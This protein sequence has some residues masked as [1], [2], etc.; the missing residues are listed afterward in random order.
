MTATDII[1]LISSKRLPY[2]TEL[3]LQDALEAVFKERG[4]PYTREL[5]LNEKDRIDFWVDGVGIEVKIKGAAKQT[6]RQCERYCKHDEIKELLL[7]T[8]K[9]IGFPPDINGKP[10]YVYFLSMNML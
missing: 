8:T 10:C 7:I 3:E 5:R 1:T 4:Y 6:Y 2:T 9:S